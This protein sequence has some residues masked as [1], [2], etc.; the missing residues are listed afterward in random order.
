M[1]EAPFCPAW[2]PEDPSLILGPVP[3]PRFF[4]GPGALPGKLERPWLILF[5]QRTVWSLSPDAP[6]GEAGGIEGGREEMRRGLSVPKGFWRGNRKGQGEPSLSLL[7][8]HLYPRH[9]LSLREGAHPATVWAL[10][11]FEQLSPPHTAPLLLTHVPLPCHREFT[12]EREKAKSR[13]TFQKL[14]EKQQ[15]EEDLRGYMSWIT[16]GEVMDVEDLR[17]G[18]GP[19]P[20]LPQLPCQCTPLPEA[21]AS[22]GGPRSRYSIALCR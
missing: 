22:L 2:W 5:G 13:G 19:G 8:G 20:R 11:V 18:S 9:Q 14:R 1:L 15:L 6:Q 10:S 16:Q 21:P 17:E 7:K 12:K 4:Q 3:V